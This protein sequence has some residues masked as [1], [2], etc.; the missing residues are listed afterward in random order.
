MYDVPFQEVDEV[1]LE[2]P[3]KANCYICP[4]CWQAGH[5]SLNKVT[6]KQA[7][8]NIVCDANLCLSREPVLKEGDSFNI[9]SCEQY[10]LCEQCSIGLILHQKEVSAE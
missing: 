4:R 9:C 6:K 3:D 7:K 1:T 8:K 5:F 10:L 2:L